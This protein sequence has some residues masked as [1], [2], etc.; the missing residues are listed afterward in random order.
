MI[1]VMLRTRDFILFITTAAFLVIAIGATVSWQSSSTISPEDSIKFVDTSDQEYT[2]EVYEPETISREENLENMRRKIAEGGGVALSA[3]AIEEVEVDD[4][5][6]EEEIVDEL[7]DEEMVAVLQQCPDSVEYTGSW[8]VIDIETETIEGARIFYR[9]VA[10]S[11]SPSPSPSTA[12]TALSLSPETE[13][14][15]LLQL[16]IRSLPM[17]RSSCITSDVIGI[18][19]DGSLIRNNEVG[20]YGVFGSGTLI[21]YALDGFPIYG[22][23]DVVPDECGGAVVNGLYGYY[24]SSDREVILNCFAATPVSF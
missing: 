17:L 20:L 21:G 14:E 15:I 12:T 24:L 18:A 13:R 22:V 10:V 16:P 23:G 19:Q 5:A 1:L 7:P 4:I 9:E 2:A 6:E 11:P 8:S 3:P